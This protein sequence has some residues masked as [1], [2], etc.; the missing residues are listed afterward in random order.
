MANAD[1][2]YAAAHVARLSDKGYIKDNTQISKKKIRTWH[3]SSFACPSKVCI[4][5]ICRVRMRILREW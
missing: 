4:D 5:A 2:P 1:E 3:G